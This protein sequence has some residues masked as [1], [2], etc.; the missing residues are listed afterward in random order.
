MFADFAG[1]VDQPEGVKANN[2][3]EKCRSQGIMAGQ[4]YCR[5]TDIKKILH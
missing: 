4:G 3:I 5:T 1:F 2:G